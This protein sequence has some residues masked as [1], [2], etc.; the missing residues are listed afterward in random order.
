MIQ[1]AGVPAVWPNARA[2]VIN[3]RAGQTARG[4][5]GK[6]EG[7]KKGNKGRLIYFILRT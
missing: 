7:E 1:L 2:D 4:A 5:P 3:F 6:D